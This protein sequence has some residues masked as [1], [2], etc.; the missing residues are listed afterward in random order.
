MPTNPNSPNPNESVERLSLGIDSPRGS[1]PSMSIM[2]NNCM[3]FDADASSYG[4]SQM[5]LAC[6]AEE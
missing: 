1:E 5:L 2:C 6:F 4:S 3:C